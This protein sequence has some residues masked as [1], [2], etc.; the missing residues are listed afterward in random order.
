MVAIADTH[1]AALEDIFAKEKETLNEQCNAII[2]SFERTA[3]SFAQTLADYQKKQADHI[4]NMGEQTVSS[5]NDVSS[6][7]RSSS[8]AMVTQFKTSIEDIKTKTIAAIESGMETQAQGI[9]SMVKDTTETLINKIKDMQADVVKASTS[10]QQSI[11]DGIKAQTKEAVDAFKEGIGEQT[12]ALDKLTKEYIEKVSDLAKEFG[13]NT[14]STQT[15][16]D[17]LLEQ[18]K[19]NAG[20][21]VATISAAMSSTVQESAEKLKSGIDENIT[22]LNGLTGNLSKTLTPLVASIGT[23]YKDY[24][25]T[26]KSAENILKKLEDAE[27][28]LSAILSTFNTDSEDVKKVYESLLNISEQNR[29]LNYRLNELRLAYEASGKP[30]PEKCPHCG[31]EVS[32]PAARYC[33]KCGGSLFDEKQD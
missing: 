15:I 28:K 14:Q 5:L 19:T 10:T 20:N 21:D 2:T 24:A 32:D 11:I 31:A 12:A 13:V 1:A 6:D 17:S 18:M 29:T 25:K 3:D 9:I 4:K 7:V 22:T 33:G 23:S 16:L 30:L 8:E 27:S 26:F